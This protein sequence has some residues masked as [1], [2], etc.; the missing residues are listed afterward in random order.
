MS[1][2]RKLFDGFLLSLILAIVVANLAPALGASGGV[3]QM[4]W[5]T[6]I[7]ISVVFF[8]NGASLAPERLKAGAAN[9]R[10]HLLVTTSTFVIFPLI[11]LA[12]YFGLSSWLPAAL[13]LGVFYLCAL[14]STVSSSVAMT[15]MARGNVA[16]AV[17]NATLSSLLGMMITPL[18]VGLLFQH[19]GHGLSLLE[20]LRSIAIQ[21]FLPF[22]A[23]QLLR[24]LLKELLL[25]HRQLVNYVDR[26]VI[27]LIVYNSFCDSAMAHIWSNYSVGML[28]FVAA[29][30]SV[31]LFVALYLTRFAARRAG[32][33]VEDEITAV[34][35]GSK[36]SLAAGIPMAKLIFGAHPALG[37]IVLPIMFYHQIQ[38][39]VCSIIAKRY[40]ERTDH[41]DTPTA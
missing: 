11:G 14:P 30:V 4:D 36:K 2:L 27:V 32:F 10:L 34:F 13:L 35:C 24:P 1:S 29:I 17:F 38:L 21:L 20:Q 39:F 22:V 15:S 19:S 7:G 40:A 37:L 18:L 26:G 8:L 23:G 28:L 12:L 9:W 33:S 16:G 5:I 31:V 25:K 6:A 3:L 41:S